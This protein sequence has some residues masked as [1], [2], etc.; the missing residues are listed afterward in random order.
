VFRLF[1]FCQCPF[2]PASDGSFKPTRIAF[3]KTH[4]CQRALTKIQLAQL[5]DVDPVIFTKWHV[6]AVHAIA[7]SAAALGDPAT[8]ISAR[9][10]APREKCYT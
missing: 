8:L 4:V 5:D 6:A 2:C 9:I 1:R 7:A 3:V 10:S